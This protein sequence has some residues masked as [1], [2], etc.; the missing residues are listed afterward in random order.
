MDGLRGAG[1]WKL[2]LLPLL[3]RNA[4]EHEPVGKVFRLLLNNLPRKL[5]TSFPSLTN[6][7][8]SGQLVGEQKTKICKRRATQTIR[9]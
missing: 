2:L 5:A 3:Q 4:V 7:Q 6:K 1:D 8:T 9:R